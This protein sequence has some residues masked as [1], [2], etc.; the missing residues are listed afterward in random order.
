MTELIIGRAEPPL[1][2]LAIPFGHKDVSM[3]DRRFHAANAC[4]AQLMANGFNIFSPISHNVPIA[5]INSLRGWVHWERNDTAILKACDQLL[6]LCL[7]GWRESEG[8]AAEIAIAKQEGMPIRYLVH[9][10]EIADKTDFDRAA[11]AE[12]DEDPPELPRLSFNPDPDCG[13]FQ[14]Y[15]FVPDW[16]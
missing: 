12:P 1:I 16:D 9:E 6:V 11:E 8:V 10:D 2:Y 15:Y 14:I 7:D 5:R 13:G 4:A 3:R